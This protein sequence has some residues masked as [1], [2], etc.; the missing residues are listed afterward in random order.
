MKRTLWLTCLAVLVGA[1]AL[2]A[3]AAPPE[4]AKAADKP[5]AAP[6]L[7]A[8]EKATFS[9]QVD[10]FTQVATAGETEKDPLL[11]LSAARMLDELP[12]G[13]IERPKAKPDAEPTVYSRDELL[14]LAKEYAAGD[15]ELLAVI[16]KVQDAPEPTAVRGRVRER[17]HG[18]GYYYERPY[19]ERRH[20]CD[21][22][23]VCGRH[24]CDW[25]CDAP[26]YERRVVREVHRRA[27]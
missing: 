7:T 5:A 2:A 19:H 24:G 10:L 16:A 3:Q 21:W 8:Q 23:R 13:G 6:T 27:H 4:A 18:P 12:F 14:K 1:T 26:R 11:L 20:G 25:V 15:A 17:H 9:K 22:V